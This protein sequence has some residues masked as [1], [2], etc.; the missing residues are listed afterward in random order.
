MEPRCWTETH[1][2]VA[3]RTEDLGEESQESIK[4]SRRTAPHHQQNQEGRNPDNLHERER[5]AVRSYATH[6]SGPADLLE[7]LEEGENIVATGAGGGRRGRFFIPEG[8][9]GQQETQH[10]WNGIDPQLHAQYTQQCQLDISTPSTQGFI[11]QVL[12]IMG[13]LLTE[14]T[15]YGEAT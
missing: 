15:I 1:I 12:T 3:V 5:D 6:P 11:G 8:H 2:R 10:R 13:S 9:H 14:V 4:Q 7:S